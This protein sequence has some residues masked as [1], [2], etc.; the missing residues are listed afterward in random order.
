MTTKDNVH[1]VTDADLERHRQDA[2][3][4][5]QN[6][7]MRGVSYDL[8]TELRKLLGSGGYLLGEPVNHVLHVLRRGLCLFY[9][10][11]EELSATVDVHQTVFLSSYALF[12]L[13]TLVVHELPVPG[14][15]NLASFPKPAGTFFK[16]GLGTDD[17]LKTLLSF[18]LRVLTQRAGTDSLVVERADDVVSL[19]RDYFGAARDQMVADSEQLPNEL[20]AQIEGRAI[21][22]GELQLQGFTSSAQV[23]APQ[24]E[25][26]PVLPE[27][28]VGNSSAKQAL[29]RYVDRLALYDAKQGF[30][31]VLELGGLPSTVLFDGFPGTGKTSLFR[32][33]MTRMQQRSE[34]VS[35][36]THFVQI[37]PSIK[38]E[39]YGRTGKLLNEKLGLVR[40]RSALVLVFFDDVDL[41]LL[42]RG[43][44]GMGGADKDVLNITMQFLDGAF[45][46]H[47]GNAQTYAATNEPT[48]TDSALRQRFHQRELIDGPESWQDY[49]RLAQI[50]LAR[51]MQHGLIQV[52]GD[53]IANSNKATATPPGGAKAM[54]ANRLLGRKSISWQEI[55]EL[56]VELKRK[57]PRFT[58]RPIE[59]VTQTLL[60]ESANFDI[61]ETWY[62]DPTLYLEKP[63]DEKVA[64]LTSLYRPITGEMI[65]E[66]LE[67]YFNSEQRYV[68]EAKTQRAARMA[69]E[70]EAQVAARTLVAQ[71]S[72]GQ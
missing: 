57:D 64:L 39:Y 37:D 56:C 2:E 19:T 59:S 17:D 43:D 26:T 46:K 45:T 72:G 18:Y 61:P 9:E 6:I 36:P 15:E 71:R 30:N 41:L 31:P 4:R 20:L 21:R 58:G 24:V 12:G 3:F 23:K 55:G 62:T 44:P 16:V 32:M 25:W 63:Y 13:A 7:P 52:S 5:M 67:Q 51:Q 1:P 48:A 8:V 33:A 47:V 38:D 40:D 14:G 49:A 70:L 27:Q 53:A 69:S 66:A 65:A 42:S 35:L 29:L 60:A 54:L 10:L 68:T 28:V 11:Y 50:K 22:V 34:Q